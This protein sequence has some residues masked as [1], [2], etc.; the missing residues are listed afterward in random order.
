MRSASRVTLRRC[1]A[2]PG[3]IGASRA[4]MLKRLPRQLLRAR[5]PSS[6]ELARRGRAGRGRGGFPASRASVEAA[7]EFD[8]G[9]AATLIELGLSYRALG[10]RD[11]ARAA[12]ERAVAGDAGSALAL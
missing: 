8:A 12:F 11:E 4:G 10:R 6:A 3:G 2:A 9:D 5:A 1:T 7:L